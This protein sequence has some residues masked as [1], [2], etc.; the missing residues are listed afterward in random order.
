[1]IPA[2]GTQTAEVVAPVT[3]K[4]ISVAKTGHAY[5]MKTADGVE[6]L[7]HI[8]IDTVALEGAGFTSLVE[9]K[10]EIEAGTPLADVD[11]ASIVA[12]NTNPTVITTVVNTK[13]VASV[14]DVAEPNPDG[15]VTTGAPILRA[16][17]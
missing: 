16:T 6:I 5:G 2:P 14:D 9:R 8:G 1:M 11:F 3:G 15:T 7:V 4:V 10:Q 17:K 12:S 13:K